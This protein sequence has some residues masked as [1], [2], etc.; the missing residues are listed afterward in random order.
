MFI[1]LLLLNEIDFHYFCYFKMN[2]CKI[3]YN[4][5]INLST[6][7]HFSIIFNIKIYR[8]NYFMPSVNRGNTSD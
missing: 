1:N 7:T 5:N 2:E 3:L 8:I 4:F 6:E